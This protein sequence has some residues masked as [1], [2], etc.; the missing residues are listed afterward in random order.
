MRFDKILMWTLS[1]R[2][3]FRR[4]TRRMPDRLS[5]DSFRRSVVAGS[6]AGFLAAVIELQNV[7]TVVVLVRKGYAGVDA[8]VLGDVLAVDAF[9]DHS[10]FVRRLHSLS[11]PDQTRVRFELEGAL[12]VRSEW[13]LG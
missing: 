4:F 9:A 1:I 2:R 6:L 3:Q 5:G 13:S 10:R 7:A 12:L 8:L 11:F